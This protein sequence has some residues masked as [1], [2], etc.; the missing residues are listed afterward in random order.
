MKVWKWQWSFQA[1]IAIASDWVL[2]NDFKK[3]ASEMKNKKTCRM[4]I[5]QKYFKMHKTKAIPA[6]TEL[7]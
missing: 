2:G 3:S 7:F 4:V 1:A 5:S 6:L